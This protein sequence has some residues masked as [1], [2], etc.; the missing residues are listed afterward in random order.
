MILRKKPNFLI[1]FLKQYSLI[2]NN[3]SLSADVNYIT[4]KRLSIVTFSDKHIGKIIQNLDSNKAHEHDIISICLLK[5]CG[6]SI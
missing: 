2:P 5:M 6:D 1:F 4:G 3:N